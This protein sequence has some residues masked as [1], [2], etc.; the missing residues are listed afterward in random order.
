MPGPKDLLE[1]IGRARRPQARFS[2]SSIQCNIRNWGL[3][4]TPQAHPLAEIGKAYGVE[5]WCVA[6]GNRHRRLS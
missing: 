4:G 3:V 6:L 1:T 5:R 2:G